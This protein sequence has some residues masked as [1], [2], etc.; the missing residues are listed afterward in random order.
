MIFYQKPGE[1]ERVLE[2]ASEVEQLVLC[3]GVA[4]VLAIHTSEWLVVDSFDHVCGAM[5]KNLCGVLNMFVES[6]KLRNVVMLSAGDPATAQAPPGGKLYSV[7]AGTIE[8]VK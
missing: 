2:M 8:E 4:I 6:G 3:A 7:N 1:Q 5:R